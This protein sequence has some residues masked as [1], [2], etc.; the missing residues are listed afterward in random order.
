MQREDWKEALQLA[1][2]IL[3]TGS[4]NALAASLCHAAK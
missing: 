1:I 3:P 4:G 2:G